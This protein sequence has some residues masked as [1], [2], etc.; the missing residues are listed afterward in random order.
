MSQT[1][2]AG[3]FATDVNAVDLA[4][5]EN[6][7]VAGCC[8]IK[9]VL[10]T[11][12]FEPKREPV[13]PPLVPDLLPNREPAD[14]LD[15]GLFPNREVVV[16]VLAAN[17]DDVLGVSFC[18]VNWKAGRCFGT[19]LGCWGFAGDSAAGLSCSLKDKVILFQNKP[20]L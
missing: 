1:W 4:E 13:A 8:P 3:L 17:M 19:A 15:S 5:N 2:T 12:G 18:G 14:E 16:S 7:P 20:D 6:P 11:S 9:L 10:L